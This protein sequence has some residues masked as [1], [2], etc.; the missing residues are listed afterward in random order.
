[1]AEPHFYAS[2]TLEAELAHR[3]SARDGTDVHDLLAGFLQGCAQQD[4]A[5]DPV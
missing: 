2:I 1:M 4:V 3:G 5:L